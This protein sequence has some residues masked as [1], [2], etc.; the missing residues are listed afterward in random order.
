MYLAMLESSINLSL[1]ASID[2]AIL[3]ED[4][5]TERTA[6][7]PLAKMPCIASTTLAAINFVMKMKVKLVTM[8]HA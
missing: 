6:K 4:C 3:V 8:A 1:I 2:K 7:I 5:S